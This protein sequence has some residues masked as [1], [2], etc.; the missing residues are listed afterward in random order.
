MTTTTFDTLQFVRRLKAAGF[1]E[2]QA[3]A[4]T[5]AVKDAV[6]SAEVVTKADLR[7]AEARLEAK[8]EAATASLVKWLAGLLLVQ[9]GV[10]A[11]LV[12]LL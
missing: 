5:E 1:A 8:L 3:E 4:L 2:P 7:E 10:V 9:A 11:A 6:V 12:R